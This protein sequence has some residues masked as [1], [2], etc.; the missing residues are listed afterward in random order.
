MMV[1]RLYADGNGESHFDTQEIA[2]SL[3][4]FAPPAAPIYVSEP[5]AAS[6]F[7]LIELPVAWGGGQPHPTPSRHM[8]FCLSGSF[9]IT[10]SDGE[11][12]EF[13]IGDALLMADTNGK[14][15]TTTVTS[16]QPAT[17]LMIRLE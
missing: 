8:M 6:R 1:L 16:G 11:S 13:S 9:K 3:Q 12:R 2:M 5:Q 7:V 10:A 17:V 15:H 14:G 4:E